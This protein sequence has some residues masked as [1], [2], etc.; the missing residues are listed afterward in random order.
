MMMMN[1]FIYV[2]FHWVLGRHRLGRYWR[3]T[4]GRMRCSFKLR[5]HYYKRY[6][7][8]L[9][10]SSQVMALHVAHKMNEHFGTRV[11]STHILF[12]KHAIYNLNIISPPPKKK[13]NVICKIVTRQNENSIMSWFYYSELKHLARAF[14]SF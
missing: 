1:W 5:I 9:A 3:K 8:F 12:T 4:H 7:S 2:I 11:T 14:N 6:T 10:H 13:K